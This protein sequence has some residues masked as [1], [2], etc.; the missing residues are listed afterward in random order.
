VSCW[1]DNVNGQLGN[2]TFA[3]S[4]VPSSVSGLSGVTSLIAGG[5]YTC[6]NRSNGT[7]ACWGENLYGQLGNGAELPPPPDPGSP[8]PPPLKENTP[9]T[10]VG[11]SG[12]TAIGRGSDHSCAI[13]S[14]G[15]TSCVGRNDSG[16]LGDNTTTTRSTMDPVVG[17]FGMTQITGGDAH[18]C[19]LRSNGT[20]VCWGDNSFGQLGDNTSSGSLEPVDVVGL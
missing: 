15:F 13:T 16:Q 17:L 20:A 9:Q 14:G 2:G 6:V 8:P 1:G 7:P 11:V 4:S 5:G 3:S 10:V 12:A 19:A 18:S